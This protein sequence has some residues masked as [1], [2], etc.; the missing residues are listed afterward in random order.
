MK[1]SLTISS[2]LQIS[3]MYVCSLFELQ[4]GMRVENGHEVNLQPFQLKSKYSLN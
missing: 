1:N 3:F 2:L 4:I